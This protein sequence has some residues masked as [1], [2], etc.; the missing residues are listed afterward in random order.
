MDLGRDSLES[1]MENERPFA[2]PPRYVDAVLKCTWCSICFYHQLPF[3][4]CI[5]VKFPQEQL[6]FLLC[7]KHLIYITHFNH[8]NRTRKILILSP[9]LDRKAEIQ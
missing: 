1:L 5:K 8:H 7:A 4:I 3:T 9:C 2:H 6:T